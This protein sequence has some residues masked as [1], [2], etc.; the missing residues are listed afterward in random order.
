MTV[1]ICVSRH[2]D[3]NRF[4]LHGRWIFFSCFGLSERPDVCVYVD[5]CVQLFCRERKTGG[6]KLVKKKPRRRHTDVSNQTHGLQPPSAKP[7]SDLEPNSVSAQILFIRN[8]KSASF[9]TYL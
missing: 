2:A 1:V 3:V 9:V 6:M 5:V 7:H 4:P 8:Q